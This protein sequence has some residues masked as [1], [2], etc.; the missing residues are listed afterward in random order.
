MHLGQRIPVQKFYVSIDS[1][2][3]YKVSLERSLKHIAVYCSQLY[4]TCL[5]A[6]E[7]IISQRMG[8]GIDE[9][10]LLHLDCK[11]LLGINCS[12]KFVQT[13]RQ[14]IRGPY[15]SCKHQEASRKEAAT[16]LI[17]LYIFNV[18]Y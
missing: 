12:S 14:R 10:K 11:M 6:P 9:Q 18:F 2:S 16:M 8:K 5:L 1:F 17:S 3:R 7:Q 15:H 4:L 13:L